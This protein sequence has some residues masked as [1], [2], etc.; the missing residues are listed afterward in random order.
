M[1]VFLGK[2]RMTKRLH[3]LMILFLT[4]VGFML[5]EHAYAY[6]PLQ[7]QSGQPVAGTSLYDD[8][9]SGACQFTG[10]RYIF[11]TVICQ[12]VT[13]INSIMGKLYCSIQ[14]AMLPTIVALI[15]VYIV[16]YGVQM[17]MGT[18]QL[19]GTEVITRVIKMCLVLWLTTDPA[20]G[21]SAGINLMFNFFITFIS[22]STRWVVKILDQAEG[23]NLYVNYNYSPGVTA[24]FKFLDDWIYNALTGTLSNANAKVIGFFVAMGVA[25]PSIAIMALYWLVS[26]V[27][28]LI[29]TLIAFLMAVIAIA[30][31]LGLSPIFLCFML[32]HITFSYFDQWVRFMV[33]YSIQVMVSFAILTL[34]VFSMTLF[35]PFFNDLSNVLFPYEKILRPAAAIYSAANT[36][37]VCPLKIT[38]NPIPKV[39]CA[40]RGFNPIGPVKCGPANKLN[41][42]YDD[43]GNIIDPRFAEGI[44]KANDDYE[45]IIPPTK[46]IELNNFIFYI[47][48][49]MISLIIVS[50]GF[51][52]LQRNSKDIAKQLA[53]PYYTPL[54]N[55]PGM[56]TGIRHVAGAPHEASR[57]MSKNLFSGFN[58]QH[59]T[60]ATPYEKLMQGA[61]KMV[62]GR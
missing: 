39:Q 28:M 1:P 58:Q 59:E 7:C 18:A 14:A 48:Y 50:Y 60:K 25:M 57:L 20:F 55:A 45:K 3:L 36:W 42:C 12:F 6:S 44:T 35:T 22:E 46:I 38:A 52:Q 62:S 27:K 24:T 2:Q 32:F 43:Q 11:S 61:G 9:N 53:G 40:D 31:L 33:S 51:A 8:S 30:F 54:L 21:V 34:W 16:V 4:F 10:M 56:G 15:T 5:P 19:N 13:M 49:H 17:L 29:T 26:L 37:G 23:I 47:F 41:P